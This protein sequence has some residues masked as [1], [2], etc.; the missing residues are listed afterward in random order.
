[1]GAAWSLS[2]PSAARADAWVERMLE[3]R[4]HDFGTVLAGTRAVYKFPIKNVYQHEIE[5][6]RVRSSCGCASARLEGKRLGP[7]EVGF[8]IADFNTRSFDGPHDSTLT[9]EVTWNDSGVRRTGEATVAVRGIIRGRVSAEPKEVHF[10]DVPVG[11][12][13]QQKLRISAFG[14]P[15]WTVKNI[16]CSC[17][18]VYV[19]LPKPLRTSQQVIYDTMVELSGGASPGPIRG[20]L[21]VEPATATEPVLEVPISGR[22]VPATWASPD[23]V[24][25]GDVRPGARPSKRFVIR[26]RSP[27]RILSVTTGKQE[28][29]FRTSDSASTRHILEIDFPIADQ[30]GPWKQ[31]IEVATDSGNSALVM[32]FADVVSAA[33]PSAHED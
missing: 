29:K 7:K 11:S 8:L 32:A 14:M 24:F 5:L 9:L 12:A 22:V 30:P 15:D 17:N 31:A 27:C 19:K 2:L 18:D 23:F 21:T 10:A 25:L 28:L 33:D 16:Q 6:S 3:T 4:K 20:Q 1:V 13:A 26:C